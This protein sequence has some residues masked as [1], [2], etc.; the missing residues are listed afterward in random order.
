MEENLKTHRALHQDNQ[1]SVNTIRKVEIAATTGSPLCSRC[2]KIS[3]GR[4]VTLSPVTAVAEL[5]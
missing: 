3:S 4:V 1:A 5:R 2:E